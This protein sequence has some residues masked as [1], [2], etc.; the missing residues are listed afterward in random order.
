TG[1]IRESFSEYNAARREEST[2]NGGVATDKKGKTHYLGVYEY[3]GYY[4]EFKTMGAKKY[5]YRT[6]DGSLHTTIAGVVKKIGGAELDAHGG[7]HAMKEGFTF[8]YAGG[9][10]VVYQDE[11]FGTWKTPDGK[12]IYISKNCSIVDST[13]RL[14]V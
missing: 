14:S 2:K 6:E 4:T 10:D 9:K 11:D 3:D 13:Y 1:D 7:L 5:A 8:Y 12:E